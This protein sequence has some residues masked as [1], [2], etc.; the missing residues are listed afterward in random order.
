[1][2]FFFNLPPPTDQIPARM[3]LTTID[4]AAYRATQVPFGPVHINCPF[5]DP[6]EDNPEEWTSMCLSG[7][8]LWMSKTEPFTKYI[9]LY[10]LTAQYED[11]YEVTEVLQ[12]IQNAKKGLLLIGALH[13]ED[14]IWAAL[15]LTKH[16][17]WP[18]VADVLS[19][20][21]MRRVL[22]SFPEI[23]DRFLFIDHLDHALLS[24]SVKN[25]AQPDVV[26]QVCLLDP[27]FLLCL[28]YNVEMPWI[29]FCNS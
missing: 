9:R 10:N 7:L 3:V 5:R 14:E 20:L 23:D 26:V 25:W 21:R 29:L 11:G 17:F 2:R 8:D 6:L 18:V 22:S 19:G 4:S 16:L 13:T 28:L 15:H 12:I 1:V 27:Q 24:D